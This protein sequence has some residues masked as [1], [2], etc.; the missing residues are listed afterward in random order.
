MAKAIGK[1]EIDVEDEVL[2]ELVRN[3]PVGSG[4]G[5][6]GKPPKSLEAVLEFSEFGGQV[7]FTTEEE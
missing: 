4:S 6:D 2:L 5:K 7:R 3:I 1:I